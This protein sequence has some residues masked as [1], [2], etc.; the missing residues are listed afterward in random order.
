LTYIIIVFIFLHVA[1]Q[2]VSVWSILIGAT[3]LAQA[4]S[5]VVAFM[6]KSRASLTNESK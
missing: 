1:L 4:S 2:R 5:H 3:L 6:R